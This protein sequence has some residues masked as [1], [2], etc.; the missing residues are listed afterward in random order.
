VEVTKLL[1]MVVKHVGGHHLTNISKEQ[2]SFF[3]EQGCNVKD[4]SAMLGMSESCGKENGNL[5]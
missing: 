4:V 5:W 1:S 2:L 3:I